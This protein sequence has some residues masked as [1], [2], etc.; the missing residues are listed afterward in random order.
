MGSIDKCEEALGK[1]TTVDCESG[2]SCAS[3][4]IERFKDDAKLYLLRAKLSFKLLVISKSQGK[5]DNK[6]IKNCLGDCEQAIAIIER[7]LM[8]GDS[9][10]AKIEALQ[11]GYLCCVKLMNSQRKSEFEHRL[12]E[13]GIAMPANTDQIRNKLLRLYPGGQHGSSELQYSLKGTNFTSV[14][15]IPIHLLESISTCYSQKIQACY[16]CFL[17]HLPSTRQ[18]LLSMSVASG[19][20]RKC[21][22][23]RTRD[24]LII[25]IPASNLCEPSVYGKYVGIPPTPKHTDRITSFKYCN[26]YERTADHTTCLRL[27]RRGN[28]WYPHSVEEIVIWTIEYKQG[29][30]FED[31]YKEYCKAELLPPHPPTNTQQHEDYLYCGYCNVYTANALDLE[32]HCKQ[33]T[34]KYAVFADS[35]R[36]V[37]WQFKPPLPEDYISV[38]MHGVDKI[39]EWKMRL[40]RRTRRIEEI[41]FGLRDQA[42]AKLDITTGIFGVDTKLE[43]SCMTLSASRVLSARSTETINWTLSIKGNQHHSLRG[44]RFSEES[45]FKLT[46]V[47]YCSTK[48]NFPITNNLC[49][50]PDNK[51]GILLGIVKVCFSAVPNKCDEYNNEILIDVGLQKVLSIPVE[52]KVVTPQLYKL[53]KCLQSG[54][55][56]LNTKSIFS[57]TTLE[58][59]EMSP[60]SISLEDKQLIKNFQQ[61]LISSQ[62][63]SNDCATLLESDDQTNYYKKLSTLVCLEGD[64]RQR[65]VQRISR[66]EIMAK[67]TFIRG[68]PSMEVDLQE[69][70]EAEIA[71]CS[72]L[73]KFSPS[74][75]L[76]FCNQKNDKASIWECRKELTEDALLITLPPSFSIPLQYDGMDFS[77][78]FEFIAD[79][80]HLAKCYSATISYERRKLSYLLFPSNPLYHS[81]KGKCITCGPSL[82]Q[83]NVQLNPQQLTAMEA[84]LLSPSVLPVVIAGPFGTGKTFL[85]SCAVEYLMKNCQSSCVLVCTLTNSAANV[86]L[87]YFYN[88]IL[89]DSVDIL[90][91]V[92]A[93]RMITSI[94]QH[95]RERYCLFDSTKH[96]FWYPNES[97]IKKY[98]VIVTT[99][100]LAQQLLKLKLTGHFTH[101]FIDEAAQVTVPEVMMALSLASNTTKVA[102]AGDRMQTTP[103]VYSPL[104]KEYDLHRSPLEQV[105]AEYSHT[106]DSGNQI[107][108]TQNYRTHGDILKLPSKFFYRGK[109]RSCD[110]I[111][112]HPTISPLLFLES[113]DQENYLSEFESYLN[114]DEAEQVVKFLKE[115]LLP[116][117]PNDLWGEKPNIAILTTEYAQVRYIRSVLKREKMPMIFVDTIRNAQGYEFRVVILSIVRT[118]ISIDKD[119]IHEC[120]FYTD[121]RALNTAF[122]RVQSL[123][124]TAAHPLSIITRGNMSCRLFWA[125]YLSQSMKDDK[126]NQLKKQL[127]K[128]CN[129]GQIAKHW[130]LSPEDYEVYSALTKHGEHVS[131]ASN[132]QGYFDQIL[133]D[134][135][136]ENVVDDV[137]TTSSHLAGHHDATEEPQIIQPSQSSTTTVS[138]SSTSSKP[139]RT[140]TK[141]NVPLHELTSNASYQP[142]SSIA[143][144]YSSLTPESRHGSH[145]TASNRRSIARKFASKR[146]VSSRRAVVSGLHSPYVK[147]SANSEKHMVT[148]IRGAESGYAIVLD[149]AEKDIWLSDSSALNRS[150]RGDTVVVKCH[151][152]FGKR[153][154]EVVANISSVEYRHPKK[155]F[156]C[157]SDRWTRN[158]LVP[159]DADY[160]KIDT[161]QK[162]ERESGLS[163]FAGDSQ[164]QAAVRIKYEDVLKNVYLVRLDHPWKE[165]H[166]YP[167]GVPVKHFSLEGDLTA[168]LIKILKYNYIPA[169]TYFDGTFSPQALNQARQQFPENWKI[170]QSEIRKRRRYNN[171]FTIDDEE[172]VVM[173]DALS[174][175]FDKDGNFVVNV[176]IADAS[177]FIKPRSA[178]DRDALQRGRTFYGM[179]EAMFML[180]DEIC[181]NHGSLQ[182]GKDRLAV[183]TQFVFSKTDHSLLTPLSDV[184]VHKSI[185]CS[186]CKLTKEQVGKFLLENTLKGVE[187]LTPSQLDKLKKDLSTLNKIATVL[188]KSQWPDS[189]LYQPDRGTSNKYSLEG[190]SL[191]EMFMCLCNK[192]IPAKLLKINK[193]VGPVVV[194]QPIKHFKQ[195]EWLSSHQHLLKCCP[196]FN[197]M[198]SSEA[199]QSFNSGEH[200]QQPLEDDAT[201]ED[202]YFPG[203]I[204]D[205]ESNLGSEEYPKLE[206]EEVPAVNLEPDDVLTI[207]NDTWE[208]IVGSAG[209]RDCSELATILCSLDN[210]PELYVAYRKL[211]MSQTKAFYTVITSNSQVPQYRH[212]HFGTVYSHFTSPLRRYPDILL[213]RAILS[214]KNATLPTTE[215]LQRMSIHKWDERKFSERRD[216]LYVVNCCKMQAGSIA[217]TAYVGQ[218]SNKLMELHMSPQL[219]EFLSDRICEIR[220]SHLQT[221][222]DK[223][224]VL[225][226]NVEMIPAPLNRSSKKENKRKEEIELVQIPVDTL[227]KVVEALH[228][229]KYTKAKDLIKT[230]SDGISPSKCI[231][232]EQEIDKKSSH[233]LTITK[234]IRENSTL[235]IQISSTHSKSYS[236]DPTVS[237]VHISKTFSCCLLHVKHPIECYA[238]EILNSPPFHAYNT[239]SDYVKL[240]QPVVEA[241]SITNST[242][243]K[244]IPVII[245]E[246][247]LEW[248]SRNEAQFDVTPD[249][250]IKFRKP[251]ETGDLV[252]I[253]YRKLL[254]NSGKFDLESDKDKK[255]TWVAHGKIVGGS[256]EQTTKIECPRESTV[257]PTTQGFSLTDKL[258]NLEVIPLQVTFRRIN[259]MF[260]KLQK[261]SPTAKQVLLEQICCRKYSSPIINPANIDNEGDDM[262][263]EGQR[264]AVEKAVIENNK[265]LLIQ[266]PPGTGKSTTCVKLMK[267]FVE[268]NENKSPGMA[269]KVI[270]CAPSNKAVNV[271]ACEM[272]RKFPCIQIVRSFG[273]TIEKLELDKLYPGLTS[274]IPI[275]ATRSVLFRNDEDVSMLPEILKGHCLHEKIR[276]PQSQQREIEKFIEFEKQLNSRIKELSQKEDNYQEVEEL[277]NKYINL[278]K[279]AEQVVL[280]SAQIIFCTCAEAGSGR[281]TGGKIPINQCVVDECGMCTEPETILPMMLSEKFILVGDHKQLQPVVLNK[282]A[283][284]LG[285]KISMF[286][287]LFEDEHMNRYGVT[288]TT[289]Y[290]MHPSICEFPSNQFYNGELQAADEVLKRQW[291]KQLPSKLWPRPKHQRCVFIHVEGSEEI[292]GIDAKGSYEESKYNEKEAKVVKYVVEHLQRSNISPDEIMVLTPYRAHKDHIK[293]LLPNKVEVNTVHG[294]QGRECNVIILTTVRSLPEDEIPAHPSH[295]WVNKHMGFVTDQHLMNVAITRAREALCIIGNAHLIRKHLMWRDLLDHYE[296]QDSVI[297]DFNSN[298]SS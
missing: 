164:N 266:G 250:R 228:N 233:K 183:T 178:L 152:N 231:D 29:I 87:E 137:S 21:L 156:I 170:P 189:H 107:L 179:E 163:V 175:E 22:R 265:L 294:S 83:F 238:P 256:R 161:C 276:D 67:L 247:H 133:E 295:N 264:E 211:C 159:I 85:L 10:T 223:N 240:W 242:G 172:T 13:F 269:S 243:S 2:I 90:R 177:Y 202:E 253:Q 52:L 206:H 109:L 261:G 212:S 268:N 79:L 8:K 148:V 95:I 143:G 139:K 20:C 64:H 35:G 138:V 41:P 38:T 65:L 271:G 176:H 59:Q 273:H 165:D 191:V 169:M 44:V 30:S 112:K 75:L 92:Y 281:L 12:K 155:Y 277:T 134:L 193:Q 222:C 49:C 204:E 122:T 119:S 105:Y 31:V 258:C 98:R 260:R 217:V 9:T 241:E 181:I 110:T 128:E 224:R 33:D 94:P 144:V 25:V 140:I 209:K 26:K 14:D 225:K 5:V 121:E 188:R 157:F 184:E 104:A 88:R 6:R 154:G 32:D 7:G 205:T 42:Q 126:C 167:K 210:F 282:I 214:G 201:S 246:L 262:L 290:R 263:N 173:D 234:H 53:N 129:V 142:I 102:L 226:W 296:Q 115:T 72:M 69:L 187:G 235:D 237:L 259:I 254:P 229:D 196:L 279:L 171:V 252:C 46:K 131:D 124:I 61:Q 213:H 236:V 270:Y 130:Q 288:L 18:Q 275:Y 114:T 186:A 200:Q 220:L 168:T 89:P 221:R 274:V 76:H 203:N 286:Q 4:A 190:G 3:E 116:G 297:W 216:Q 34:H 55:L 267:R 74:V 244:R 11:L 185:V 255:V 180:P 289:Q 58:I 40:K 162:L 292:S 60:S 197:R 103:L 36:D 280:K 207:S 70:G 230:T 182:A 287:R 108:L 80:T 251:F 245:K 149:P 23:Q 158:L 73:L 166:V 239:L 28:A 24:E 1:N 199:L 195:H 285:L 232:S 111:E 27:T 136:K 57:N 78:D 82:K 215:I 39:K 62:L 248:T 249:F 147:V 106:Q 51:P 100:G 113:N 66:K 283:D 145:S 63:Y 71:E 208:K 227:A 298:I 43:C 81:Q 146:E 153:K 54:K 141:S 123:I 47:F 45:V 118:H 284:S 192:A 101:I 56:Y 132:N 218:V 37:L 86:Y 19:V 127:V 125:S 50:A 91:L 96:C 278:R 174:L 120:S 99:L 272:L 17:T 293:E 219:H 97:E 16:W 257:L 291:G 150:L 198:I 160:P 135:E 77:I 48:K 84:I 151:S 15:E 68:P 93:Q 194:H 117:W